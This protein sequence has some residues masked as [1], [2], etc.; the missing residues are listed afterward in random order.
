MYFTSAYYLPITHATD[1]LVYFVCQGVY[2]PGELHVLL[3]LC[4]PI[5]C[6]LYCTKYSPVLTSKMCVGVGTIVFTDVR[7]RHTPNINIRMTVIVTYF[8]VHVKTHSY[9]CGHCWSCSNYLFR[10]LRKCHILII[11]C[12]TNNICIWEMVKLGDKL[13]MPI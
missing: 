9:L 6:T 7:D 4:W 12:T 3:L 1:R 5:C 10:I 11:K 2:D 8:I 13:A